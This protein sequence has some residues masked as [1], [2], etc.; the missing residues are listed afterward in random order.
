MGAVAYSQFALVARS[1]TMPNYVTTMFN[2]SGDPTKVAEF[3]EAVRWSEKMPDGEHK[4]TEFDFNR[5]IPMPECLEM[6]PGREGICINA[7]DMAVFAMLGLG[8]PIARTPTFG[9]Q[10]LYQS[11]LDS[12]NRSLEKAAGKYD[13]EIDEDAMARSNEKSYDDFIR[14]CQAIK[15]TGFPYWYEWRR[16]NW[17]TKWNACDIHLS[18]AAART[19]RRRFSCVSR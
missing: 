6:A 10:C 1:M 11:V 19:A 12:A 18:P 15:E 14:C 4:P 2:V 16:V 8:F 17:G 13:G 7:A 9:W 3:F 5:L